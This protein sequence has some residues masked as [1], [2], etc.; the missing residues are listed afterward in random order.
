MMAF[1]VFRFFPSVFKRREE[2]LR[3]SKRNL[4]RRRRR[5]LFYIILC[6][7]GGETRGEKLKVV[8]SFILG[9]EY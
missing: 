9:F 6:V 8:V 5:F 1:E 2:L 7:S 3:A 4:R